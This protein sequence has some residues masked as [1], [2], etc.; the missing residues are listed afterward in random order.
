MGSLSAYG[1]HAEAAVP[2]LI[3]LVEQPDP[4]AR[5]FAADALLHIDP[6]AAAKVGIK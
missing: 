6:E 2:S 5:S 1:R 3:E 4:I